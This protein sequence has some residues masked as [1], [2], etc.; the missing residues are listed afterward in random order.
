MAEPDAAAFD[1]SDQVVMAAIRLLRTLAQGGNQILYSTHAPVFLSVDRIEELARLSVTAGCGGS[2]KLTESQ[3][4]FMGRGV[5]A[6]FATAGFRTL[7]HSRRAESLTHLPPGARAICG[8]RRSL[9]WAQP[10]RP[11]IARSPGC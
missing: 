3:E 1:C 2:A 9:C 5:A 4:Y 8:A 11:R 10:P 6:T 7:I